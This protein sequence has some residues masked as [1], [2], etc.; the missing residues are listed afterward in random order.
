MHV[1]ISVCMYAVSMFLCVYLY[2]CV[3]VCVYVPVSMCMCTYVCLCVCVCVHVCLCL[4]VS[5]C[6]GECMCLCIGS[7]AAE[8]FT[9]AGIKEQWSQETLNKKL[10]KP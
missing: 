5:V 7:K 4:F 10:L 2:V 8:H 9:A 1:C 6:Q 3:H